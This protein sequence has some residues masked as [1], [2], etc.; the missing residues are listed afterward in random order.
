MCRTLFQH[1]IQYTK[2]HTCSTDYSKLSFEF[3]SIEFLFVTPASENNSQR[4]ITALESS[5][6]LIL[7]Y[8]FRKINLQVL[9]YFKLWNGS[10]LNI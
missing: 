4:H 8:F 9:L 1:T 5:T 6:Q 10:I 3:R 7:Y 2:W